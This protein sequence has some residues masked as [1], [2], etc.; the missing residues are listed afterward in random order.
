MARNTGVVRA[1]RKLVP[2]LPLIE[3]DD[4]KGPDGKE[5][6]TLINALADG[7]GERARPACV[8]L[9]IIKTHRNGPAP[10]KGCPLLSLGVLL[11]SFGRKRKG[12]E[13]TNDEEFNKSDDGILAALPCV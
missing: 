1:T 5:E 13:R 2:V 12:H 3:H 8:H 4:K 10:F 9:G 7:G 6:C 11:K